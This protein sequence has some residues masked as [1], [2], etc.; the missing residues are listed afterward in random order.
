MKLAIM[1]PY[2]L[3][4]IGYF[5]LIGAVDKFVIYDDVNFIK[6]GWINRNNILLNEKTHMFSLPISGISQNRKIR[7]LKLADNKAW[8]RKFISTIALSYTN[9]P[10]YKDVR[11]LLERIF[12]FQSKS[13]ADFITNS[14]KEICDYLIISTSIIP[15]SN[16]YGNAHLIGEERIIDICLQEKASIYINAAGGKKLYD[17]PSF[18][19]H[20]IELKF[21]YGMSPEYSQLKTSF[22]SGLSIIDVLM[23]N[24]KKTVL[25]Y[26]HNY[27]L[28]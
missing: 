23:F 4:Y 7:E 15:S 13:V 20:E 26:I 12:N 25:S 14:I 21:L 10:Y 24:S 22:V 8:Q 17:K 9:A 28:D 5:Q 18:L 16:I 6:K 2:F 3:P 27:R 19:E 1:Q 11:I